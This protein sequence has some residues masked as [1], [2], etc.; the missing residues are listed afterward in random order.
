MY[1]LSDMHCME[2]N[3][4]NFY[5]FKN[6]NPG[7]GIFL[8][9]LIWNLLLVCSPCSTDHCLFYG[10]H[11]EL[12]LSGVILCCNCR[13]L[14]HSYLLIGVCYRRKFSMRGC[15]TWNLLESVTFWIIWNL[16]AK[17]TDLVVQCVNKGSSQGHKKHSKANKKHLRDFGLCWEWVMEFYFC[18]LN[19]WVA[20]QRPHLCQIAGGYHFQHGWGYFL[21]HCLQLLLAPQ[22]KSVLSWPGLTLIGQL[23]VMHKK[24]SPLFA[25]GVKF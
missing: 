9:V 16:F 12:W 7:L 25:N 3:K 4:Q 20:L 23:S 15:L 17:W 22:L 6:G 8:L 1:V 14:T 2:T 21:L 5:I 18:T 19:N 13:S 11:D 24:P 10:F